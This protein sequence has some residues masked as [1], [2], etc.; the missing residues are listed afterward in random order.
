MA[1][2]AKTVANK[3]RRPTCG[4]EI[5]LLDLSFWRSTAGDPFECADLRTIFALYYDVL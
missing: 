4:P 5:Q 2:K 3:V 1:N